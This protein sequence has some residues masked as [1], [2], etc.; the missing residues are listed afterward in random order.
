MAENQE[1]YQNNQVFEINIDKIYTD[2]IQEID[3]IRSYVNTTNPN[4]TK[5][6]FKSLKPDG[7]SPTI[8][9]IAPETTLQ[10]SRCH[11][12][13]RLIGFPVVASNFRIYNPGHDIIKSPT[14]TINLS[15]KIN[16]AMTPMPGF[17]K[18]SLE[19]ETYTSRIADV[20]SIP[21][22]IDAGTLA[23]SS[24]SSGTKSINLRKFVAPLDISSDPFD[25]NTKNQS[26]TIDLTSIV[27]SNE[28]LLTKFQNPDGSKPSKL[29]SARKHIIKPF[30]VDA[31]IDFSV[32]PATRRIAVPFVPDQ[33]FT[34][35][36]SNTFA[37]RPLI[38]KII[39]DRFSVS[40]QV[41]DVGTASQSL[42]DYVKSIPTI[43]DQKIINQ[44]SSGDLYGLSEKSQFVQFLNIIQEMMIKLVDSL[45]LIHKAQGQYYWVPKPSTMGP[46]GGSTVRD[47]FI[48]TL[49]DRNLVT[50]SDFNILLKIVQSNSNQFNS[51]TAAVD[52]VPDVGGFAF[53][54]FFKTSF[55]P[56]TT[57][58]LGNTSQQTLDKLNNTRKRV[59]E[60]ANDAL[61]TVEIIM[62][63]FS[64]LGLC[65]IIAIL[66]A[67]YIMPK[68]K[69]IGFLDFD[70]YTR[71][72]SI[73]EFKDIAAATL[74]DTMESFTSTVKDFYNLM[75]KIYQDLIKNAG[76][77]V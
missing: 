24:G 3:S 30:M 19:R 56:E 69:L 9:T 25:M 2:F 60:R 70:A 66:G 44:I 8:N 49:I 22:S 26:Y 13:F 18:L 11:A 14:K 61:R 38:E 74:P 48:P 39:R 41:Q 27:G 20:F 67:L 37:K 31:K 16:I 12:F 15:D 10:E 77:S 54:G 75:D 36:S 53:D 4:N 28:I 73:S 45:R 58:S 65:D 40:N 42:I 71:L 68:E 62:G 6:L 63:E 64:G 29:S 55:S 23:L 34:K 35:I 57:E 17:D 46:E 1:S 5:N 7:N 32:Y 52:G 59:L 21:S 51:Q 72:T 47:I 50:P 76:L 43:Q 33:S